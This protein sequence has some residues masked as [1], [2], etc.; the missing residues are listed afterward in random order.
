VHVRDVNFAFKLVRRRVLE[1]VQL[2]SEGSFVDAELVVRATR[3][4]FHIVQIGVDYFPRSRGESTL[5]S[6]AVIVKI[7]RELMR[8]RRD[9]MDVRPLPGAERVG[10]G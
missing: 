6:P 2:V 5:S 9:L 3:L 1:R 10:D 8:L 4:G 7:L